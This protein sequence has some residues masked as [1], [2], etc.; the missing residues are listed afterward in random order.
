MAF[1]EDTVFCE[2]VNYS[3][4]KYTEEHLSKV[5]VVLSIL[6][7]VSV[8]LSILPKVTVDT[9]APVRV[10]YVTILVYWG[11]KSFVPGVREIPWILYEMRTHQNGQLQSEV[12]MH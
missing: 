12:C 8:V 7:K 10:R 4:V 3:C 9:D 5:S 1:A 11:Q 6:P 2:T